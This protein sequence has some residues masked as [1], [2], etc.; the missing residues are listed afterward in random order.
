MDDV[1][2][3]PLITRREVE[4]LI[5]VPMITAFIEEFGHKRTLEIAEQ[6]VRTLAL[7]AGRRLRQVTGGNRLE[8]FERALAIFGQG[9]ALETE[10]V[11]SSSRTL[12]IKVTRCKY[13][14]MYRK[15]GWEEFGRL[16]SCGRDA[17]LTQGFNP[18][19]RFT[20]TKTI[21][22]GAGYCDFHYSLE[23]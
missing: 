18:K 23:D 22:E 8:H 7:D 15:H 16:L 6:V 5:T 11:E 14:E 10:I 17:A 2:S 19:I 20:R 4:A 1:N 13:A 9:G 12:A 3:L 21:M